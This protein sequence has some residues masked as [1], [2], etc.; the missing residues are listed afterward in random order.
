MYL[1][2]YI[3]LLIHKGTSK[4]FCPQVGAARSRPPRSPTPA[5]AGLHRSPSTPAASSGPRQA[6]GGFYS[7][8]LTVG[9]GKLENGPRLIY[10]VF[11]SSLGLGGWRAVILKVSDSSVVGNEG[12]SYWD[13]HRN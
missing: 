5:G 4:Q 2:I 8:V 1:H 3:D 6:L 10:V 7:L 13:Y 11:S 12:V 9:S